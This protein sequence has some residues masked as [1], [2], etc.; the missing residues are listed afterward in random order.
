MLEDIVVGGYHIP[1]GANIYLPFTAMRNDSPSTVSD[2]DL[3]PSKFWTTGDVDEFKPDRWLNE[4]GEFDPDAG[5]WLAF[6]AG[7]RGC[8]GRNL[9]VSTYFIYPLK[10]FGFWICYRI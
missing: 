8:F 6:G 10:H 5:P 3:K 9:A 7:P 2:P 4:K 1:K